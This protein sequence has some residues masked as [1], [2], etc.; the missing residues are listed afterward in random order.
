[1]LHNHIYVVVL[2]LSN[3]LPK[4]VQTTFL[5]CEKNLLFCEEGVAG[6]CSGSYLVALLSLL[7]FGVRWTLQW[8]LLCMYIEYI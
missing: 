4:M 5:N 7:T 3:L 6:N 8:I 2:P 1:M